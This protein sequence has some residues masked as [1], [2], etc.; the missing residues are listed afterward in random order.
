MFNTLLKLNANH[1]TID[2]FRT[3]VRFGGLPLV[4]PEFRFMLFFS[5]KVGSTFIT[6]WF[7]EQT[8]KLDEAMKFS[9]I[10]TPG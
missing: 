10:D 4:D 1:V 9:E 5:A 8:G 7:F 3:N 2:D 6:K